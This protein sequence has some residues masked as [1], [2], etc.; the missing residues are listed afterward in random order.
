MQTGVYTSDISASC[1]VIA[2][3]GQPMIIPKEDVLACANAS[4]VAKVFYANHNRSGLESYLPPGVQSHL[5]L[6]LKAAQ[7]SLWLAA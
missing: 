7:T 2:H 5:V 6:P 3:V 1:E 4:P